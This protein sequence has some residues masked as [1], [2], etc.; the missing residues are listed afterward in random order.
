MDTE[1]RVFILQLY[2]GLQVLG[3]AYL[4]IIWKMIYFYGIKQE[5]I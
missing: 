2:H 1:Q 3:L 5:P 4:I